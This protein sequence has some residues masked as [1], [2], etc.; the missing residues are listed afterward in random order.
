M[1]IFVTGLITALGYLYTFFKESG[2]KRYAL[3]AAAGVAVVALFAVVKGVMVGVVAGL[4]LATPDV[5]AIGLSWVCPYNFNNCI[6][7]RVGAELAFAIYRWQH[8]IILQGAIN[9]Q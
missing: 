4:A 6:A 1:P 2:I 5:V 9:A 7:A 8:N 3:I